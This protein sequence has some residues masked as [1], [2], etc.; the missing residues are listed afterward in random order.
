MRSL[1]LILALGFVTQGCALTD[2]TLEAGP[3]AELVSAG[4]LSEARSRQFAIAALEDVRPDQERIGYKKNGFGQNTADITTDEPVTQIVADA[5]T[6]ALTA[7]GHQIATND[8]AIEGN[9]SQF[10]VDSDMN[11]WSIEIMCSIEIDLVFVDTATGQAL[12]EATYNGSFNDKFQTGMESN[13]QAVMS[14]AVEALVD[15][16][17]FDEEL[18]EA[19][20]ST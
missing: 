18:A 20:D 17:V 11:F 19:L 15:D 2:A 13:L 10:W 12:H 4:P 3:A 14:G 5:I 9:V 7:N 6:S 16:L 8:I 1:L